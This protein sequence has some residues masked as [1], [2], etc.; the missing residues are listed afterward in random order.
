MCKVCGKNTKREYDKQT[1]SF[2][3]FCE[4]GFISKERIIDG[5]VEYAHY[6]KHNNTMESTGY[7]KMFETFLKKVETHFPGKSV[8]E[9]G[10]GP[11]PVLAE[12][13]R[14]K[15]YTVKTYDKY[16]DHDADYNQHLYDVVTLT[17]VIEHFDDPVEELEKIHKLLKSGGVVAIQTMFIKQPFFD[18]WYRRDYTHISFFNDAVFELIASKIGFSVVYSDNSSI[19]VLKKEQVLI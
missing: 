2:Y 5:E 14:I 12:L 9:Y 8:L 13:L 3:D 10:C 19:I 18:W 6:A 7:V 16:F 1:K 11:G 4:C 17:E 15:D